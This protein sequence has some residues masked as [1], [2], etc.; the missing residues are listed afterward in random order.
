[1]KTIACFNNKGGVG[2]TTLLYHLAWMFSELG[3]RVRLTQ[4]SVKSVERLENTLRATSDA[5]SVL[6]FTANKLSKATV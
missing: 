4:E 5:A 6:Q 3:L 2:K 1:M